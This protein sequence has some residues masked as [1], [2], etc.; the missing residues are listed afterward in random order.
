MHN[1]DPPPDAHSSGVTAS[2]GKLDRPVTPCLRDIDSPS[3]SHSRR[4][5]CVGAV[6][7]LAFY[8]SDDIV[9]IKVSRK[10]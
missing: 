10:S 2:S 6:D 8:R 9:V 7:G 4:F 5:A 3:V 1:S